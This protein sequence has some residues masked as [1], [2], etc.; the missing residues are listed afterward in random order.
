MIDAEV[1]RYRV[2]TDAQDQVVR[3]GDVVQLDPV[4]HLAFGGWMLTVTEAAHWGVV[5]YVAWP[6]APFTARA[7]Y[8]AERATYLRVGAAAW[9]T[10]A[11]TEAG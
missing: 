5:G 9:R 10:P 2:C 7:C 1:S 8:R 6:E 4:R 11:E 3:A